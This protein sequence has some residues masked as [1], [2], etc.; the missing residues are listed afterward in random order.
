MVNELRPHIGDLPHSLCVGIL[1]LESEDSQLVHAIAESVGWKTVSLDPSPN[2]WD[3]W[4][5]VELMV[6]SAEEVVSDVLTIVAEASS[7]R[8]VPILVT[9]RDNDPQH[10][11]DVLRSGA[12]DYVVS[13][14]APEELLV[15]MRALVSRFRGLVERRSGSRIRFDHITRTVLAGPMHMSLSQREWDALAILLRSESNLVTV[16]DLSKGLTGG[17]VNETIVISTISR[18]RKKIRATRFAAISI[19]TVYGHGYVARFRR[20][21]DSFNNNGKH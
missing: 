9:A 3:A 11:A 12:S 18:L 10:L 17:E 19:E 2:A 5:D 1:G 16:E 20:S 4:D 6:I 15:R 14:F 21:N 8:D 7:Q 13:P